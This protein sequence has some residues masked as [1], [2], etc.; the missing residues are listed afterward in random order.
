MNS[1]LPEDERPV[2]NPAYIPVRV[3][4]VVYL[5]AG[6]WSGPA[7]TVYNEPASEDVKLFDLLNGDYTLTDIYNLL[8][9]KKQVRDVL[10][11]LGRQNLV[12]FLEEESKHPIPRIPMERDREPVAQTADGE[13]PH[14]TVL[15]YGEIGTIVR[16]YLDERDV[17]FTHRRITGMDD[18]PPLNGSDT[19]LFLYLSNRD[20]PEIVERLNEIALERELPWLVGQVNGFDAVVGPTIIPG[21][22]ACYRCYSERVSANADDDLY[23]VYRQGATQIDSESVFTPLGYMVESY[24]CVELSHLFQYGQGF[25]VE[26]TYSI[27]G[28]TME[29]RINDVLKAPRCDHCSELH[30]KKRFVSFDDVSEWTDRHE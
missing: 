4:D 14:C 16:K 8:E 17:P 20:K 22:T 11:R 10:H 25:T 13:H 2:V 6:P 9:D 23:E 1:S 7:L 28:V 18:I 29:A 12:Y 5:R 30:D 26:R 15:T 3:D 19:D 24:V 27:S 21:E